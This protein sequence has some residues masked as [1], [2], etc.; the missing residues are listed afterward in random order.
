MPQQPA[1]GWIGHNGLKMQGSSAPSPAAGMAFQPIAMVPSLGLA[2]WSLALAL[3]LA[4]ALLGWPSQAAIALEAPSAPRELPAQASYRCDGDPLRVRYEAGAVDDPA[5]PNNL[6]GTLPGAF[7]LLDWRGLHLQLPRTN[8][9][10]VPSYSDGRWWWRPLSADR[11]E[12][13]QRRG[14]LISYACAASAIDPSP[15]P[16]PRAA[17]G[18][19]S[20]PGA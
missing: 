19:G 2:G 17:Q 12:F 9:S 1:L 7:V 11:P 6:A 20:N 14:T 16:E 10:G 4:L 15:V 13:R 18:A 8:N 3:A 5:I